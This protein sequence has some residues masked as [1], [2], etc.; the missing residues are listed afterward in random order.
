MAQAVGED[1]YTPRADN[2]EWTHFSLP[3][4]I[5]TSCTIE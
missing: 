3:Q 4:T 5:E 2:G 1:M